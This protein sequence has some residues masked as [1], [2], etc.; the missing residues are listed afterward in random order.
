MWFV[1]SFL[2]SVILAAAFAALLPVSLMAQAPE[3][4]AVES[5]SVPS[6][7]HP[8]DV[9]P[10]ANGGVWYT[11]QHAEA[12]GYLDP[13]TGKTRHI[14][15][16]DGS[17]AHGVIVGADGTAWVTDSGLNAIVR[18]DAE[19]F[20]VK[21]FPLPLGTGYANLNTATFDHKGILWFT[22]QS[23]IYGRLDPKTGGL[24]VFKAPRGYGPYG[25][26]TAPDGN[27]YYASLAGSYVGHID[28]VSGKVEVLEPPTPDQGARRVWGDSKSRI[29]VSEWNTGQVSL[30][31]PKT[32]KWR[33][34]M[35]P[36]EAPRAYAVY[37]DENDKVWLTDFG[38]N[39]IVM[40]D[41]VTETFTSYPSPRAGAR[42]RQLLG[43]PGEVWAPESGTDTL[44]VVRTR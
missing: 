32:G 24:D 21:T 1:R 3:R 27:V 25:I 37:V 42:V 13:K 38:A 29:W 8:H 30:Y 19:T 23:G 44:V 5:F 43:R 33:S 4:A 16:G 2:C 17:A 26:A 41:P 20:A 9:A 36:G 11:A 7:S 35:L 28:T 15:L 18:V 22:G 39:A 10:A 34:W 14:P 12:L 6:G 31:D 40:F